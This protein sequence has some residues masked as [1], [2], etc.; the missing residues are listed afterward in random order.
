MQGGLAGCWSLSLRVPQLNT[1]QRVSWKHLDRKRD[2]ASR[3]EPCWYS[4]ILSGHTFLCCC[5]NRCQAGLPFTAVTASEA[6]FISWG[7]TCWHICRKLWLELHIVYLSVCFAFAKSV[8]LRGVQ[9]QFLAA[10]YTRKHNHKKKNTLY[11][12]IIN[13]WVVEINLERSNLQDY[14]SCC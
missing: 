2:G 11:K 9:C 7:K 10:S 3:G 12:H 1:C 6:S 8:F 13:L 4:P 14:H 5:Y